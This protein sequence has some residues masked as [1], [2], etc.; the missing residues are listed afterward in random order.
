MSSQPQP[1][2]RPAILIVSDTAAAD[3]STDKASPILKECFAQDG[4]GKWAEPI[5][6]IVKDD[7]LDIQRVVR[8]WSDNEFGSQSESS[9]T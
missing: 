1:L 6:E 7:V 3:P 4:A 8:L 5:V 9:T 2:L